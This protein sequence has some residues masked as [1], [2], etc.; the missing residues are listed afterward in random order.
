MTYCG[1]WNGQIY[2]SLSKLPCDWR[3]LTILARWVLGTCF[4]LIMLEGFLT[5]KSIGGPMQFSM[6]TPNWIR[7]NAKKA[8]GNIS[9]LATGTLAVMALASQAHAYAGA[10]VP[11]D[12]QISLK[13]V[14]RLQA[15]DS[16]SHVGFMEN[17]EITPQLTCEKQKPR[18]VLIAQAKVIGKGQNASD[19]TKKSLVR[20]SERY[21]GS[22][23]KHMS[24]YLEYRAE[25]RNTDGSKSVVP[26]TEKEYDRI[27]RLVPLIS[28]DVP[29]MA[30]FTHVSNSFSSIELAP[31]P[32][33]QK[34]LPITSTCTTKA[35]NIH[36]YTSSIANSPS[37]LLNQETCPE[38]SQMVLSTSMI[39]SS[40]DN[41]EQRR[42]VDSYLGIKYF[43]KQH[44]ISINSRF[45]VPL[46]SVAVN[47]T[48]YNA[49]VLDLKTASERHPVLLIFDTEK[50][51]VID[52]KAQ[53][54][55]LQF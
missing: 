37:H 55:P 13:A 28:K 53:A 31:N 1:T 19:F 24:W 21:E 6:E 49:Y 5:K 14:C 44:L 11:Y 25:L 41:Y 26:I 15:P 46:T 40:H 2:L 4:A 22:E 50:N 3:V 47:A 45:G 8:A 32:N 20:H 33:T 36:T 35:G 9:A 23:L 54:N 16:Q 38:G 18:L 29:L 27:I 34:T 42:E 17:T 39:E 43:T 48:T 51:I 10:P 30:K 7:M 12:E 52:L